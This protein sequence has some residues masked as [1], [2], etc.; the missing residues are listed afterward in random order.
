VLEEGTHLKSALPYIYSDSTL[1][2]KYGVAGKISFHGWFDI[3]D[4]LESTVLSTF[5][6]ET[7]VAGDTVLA[8]S[9]LQAVFPAV[10]TDTTNH[11]TYYF[12][13]DFATNDVPFF[14]A[15]IHR[16]DKFKGFFYSEKPEDHRRFFWLYYKPL[17]KGILTEYYDEIKGK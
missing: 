2:N 16:S 11:R 9:N 15:R 4:P 8:E 17:V 13:G 1:V 7:T 14:Y 3:I 6:L 10:I 5:K 12:S